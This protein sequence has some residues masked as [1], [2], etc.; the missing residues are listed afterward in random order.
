M[1]DGAGDHEQDSRAEGI[2]LACAA[3]QNRA[4]P[5]YHNAQL[6]S[7]SRFSPGV[8]KPP[9]SDKKSGVE[10]RSGQNAAWEYLQTQCT[11]ISSAADVPNPGV[12]R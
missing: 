2:R 3:R 12:L 9:D 5:C 4:A 7:R 11:W 10:R 1:V 8:V 6:N